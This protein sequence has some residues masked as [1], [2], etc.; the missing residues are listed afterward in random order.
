MPDEI[1]KPSAVELPIEAVSEPAC[2]RLEDQRQDAETLRL[3]MLEVLR[4]HGRRP[5]SGHSP[6][7]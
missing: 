2:P 5:G 3:V 7:E 1:R 4:R 6:A